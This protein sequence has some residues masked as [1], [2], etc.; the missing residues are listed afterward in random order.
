M[1]GAVRPTDDRTR[2][3]EHP[4]QRQ[5]RREHGDESSLQPAW[6]PD[7]DHLSHQ[8]TEIEATGM[9]QQALANVVVTAEVHATEAAGLIEMG[10]G[11]FQA[12]AAKPQ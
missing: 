5:E 3:P 12:L 6:R 8:Q 10:E 1:K 2:L 11:P 9:N 7:A 4:N